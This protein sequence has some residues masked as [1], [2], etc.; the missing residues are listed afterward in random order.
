MHDFTETDAKVNWKE[1]LDVIRRRRRWVLVPAFAVWLV[2]FTVGWLLPSKYR[3]ESV[4]LV[5]RPTVPKDYVTPN[6]DTDVREQ[7]QSMTQQIISRDRLQQIITQRHLYAGKRLSPDEVID[8]MR[9][10][11]SVEPVTGILQQRAGANNQPVA[12]QVSYTAERPLVAQQVTAQLASLFIDENLRQ[13]QQRSASTTDF[14]KAQLDDARRHLDDVSQ[15][16]QTFTTE[17]L[18]ELPD[19]TA[20]NQQAVASLQGRLQETESEITHA[21][22]QQTY[23]ASLQKQYQTVQSSIGSASPAGPTDTEIQ[24]MKAKLADLRARYKDDYPDIISLK[25]QLAAAEKS[26]KQAAAKNA[27]NDNATAAKTPTPT[28]YADLQA[29]S[30]MLQADSQ[31]KANA[32]A[33]E[34]LQRQSRVLQGQ[35]ATYTARMYS[36]PVRQQQ[37]DQ[38]NRDYQ[39]AQQN[40]EALLA[41]KNES[42]LATDLEMRQQGERFVLLDQ[43]SLPDQPD[44]PN[45]LLLSLLGLLGGFVLG[46]VFAAGRELLDDRIFTRDKVEALVPVAILATIPPLPTTAEVRQAGRVR[47]R[48][49]WLSAAAL[50]L[51]AAGSFVA[52]YRG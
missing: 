21:E 18:G 35:I 11:I 3:S 20:A 12:F 48:E 2:V 6:V 39:Q 46:G 31:L 40:Y 30:P 5:E 13:Q 43:A 42:E 34:S 9:S 44:S 51:V 26:R 32:V 52:F 38:L 37:L 19:Q 49:W 7:L 27:A 4:I 50:L 1:Y 23:L 22:Q 36:V 8:L 10:D 47:R 17:H 15:K 16:L 28:S 24:T 45:R 29:M 33:L 41:K 14:L 25:R